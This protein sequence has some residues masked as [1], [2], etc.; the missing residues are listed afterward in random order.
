MTLLGLWAAAPASAQETPQPAQDDP[1]EGKSVESNWSHVGLL[2]ARDVSPFGLLR[3]DMLPAHTA[4]ALE[5]KWTFEV[6]MAYQNTFIMSENTRDYLE[7]RNV[8]RKSL[9]GADAA[10]ILA[11]P[12]D[13]Y[14]VDGE[15]GLYDL[16]VQRR[17]SE[18]WSAYLTIPYIRYG[19][20]VLDST[21]EEFHSAFGLGQQGRDLVARNHFQIVY[22][23]GNTNLT[24]L[25]RETK[26]GLGDPVFGIRYS[27]P[28]PRFGWDV[29]VEFA[30]KIA[31]DG[32]RF[33][34][35]T[36]RNDYGTQVTL[37]RQLGRDGRHAAYLSGSAVYYAGGPETPGDRTQVIPTFIAG[38]SYGLTPRTSVILQGYVSRSVIQETNLNE[39]KEDKYLL[40]L[41]L[42]SRTKNFLW[43]LALTENVKNFENTPDIGAQIGFAYMP[44]A[45]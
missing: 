19:E 45:K 23:I 14:Y 32:K 15:V 22:G 7:K 11:L 29:V 40:S 12:G 31:L 43:S 35:S 17:L 38:Y 24:L 6:Q 2:R 9:S 3:L 21:V 27:L 39:L 44:K 8:G 37:Q 41:G 42:Q 25:D 16:I 36:G 4:D 33:L 5:D 10:A 13:A 20:G 18:Y 28:E 34:L 30:A 26:G 1:S